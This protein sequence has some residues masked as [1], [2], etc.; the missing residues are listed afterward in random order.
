MRL[1]ATVAVLLVLGLL[2]GACGEEA[3]EAS[4]D[5]QGSGGSTG[6]MV[7]A[8]LP[9]N[10]CDEVLPA[11]PADYGVDEVAHT[12]TAAEASCSLASESGATTLE[13]TLTPAEPDELDATFEAACEEVG[14]DPD[15]RQERRCTA[16][17]EQ[18]IV[19]ATSL[20]TRSAVLTM[21]LVSDDPE[22]IRT[23]QIDLA[24]VESAVATA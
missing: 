8:T 21:T 11:V 12:S 13:V 16:T 19:Q 23:G 14:P 6:E 2:S 15:G 7:N 10:L 4:S 18:Q 20:S 9:D 3:D 22:R 17:T 24:L 5:P 1:T